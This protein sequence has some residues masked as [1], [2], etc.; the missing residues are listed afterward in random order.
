MVT[1]DMITTVFDQH[2]RNM[3]HKYICI[4]GCGAVSKNMNNNVVFLIVKIVNSALQYGY[5]FSINK[6]DLYSNGFPMK[7]ESR[8]ILYKNNI[9]YGLR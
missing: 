4:G 1:D 5:I 9:W 7:K 3:R 6:E 2:F 8:Y